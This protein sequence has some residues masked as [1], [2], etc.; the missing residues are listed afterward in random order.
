MLGINIYPKITISAWFIYRKYFLDNFKRRS[1]KWDNKKN[2]C[3][4][5]VVPVTL[6]SHNIG[7]V[8]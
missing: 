6:N 1:F 7:L 4:A 8:Y 3:Q 5:I 2:C